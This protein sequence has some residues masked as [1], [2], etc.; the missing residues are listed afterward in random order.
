MKPDNINYSIILA[1]IQ[2]SSQAISI[3]QTQEKG[4]CQIT[5][6]E[7]AKQLIIETGRQL[8]VEI[9]AEIIVTLFL[10]VLP[11]LA[12]FILRKSVNDITKKRGKLGD[13]LRKL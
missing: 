11:I 3:S 6:T 1:D 9:T 2:C 4:S 5:P 7:K 13:K 12:T 8:P 10:F